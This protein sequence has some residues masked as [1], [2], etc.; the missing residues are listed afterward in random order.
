MVPP[1]DVS[2][3]PSQTQPIQAQP[4]PAPYPPHDA[5]LEELLLAARRPPANVPLVGSEDI[6]EAL[7]GAVAASPPAAGGLGDGY[8]AVSARGVQ[9]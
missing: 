7:A 5:Q 2:T 6:P 1:Y 4:I 9:R 8:G 3:G